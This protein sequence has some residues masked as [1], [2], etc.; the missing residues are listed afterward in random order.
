MTGIGRVGAGT[1]L[2]DVGEESVETDELS[3]EVDIGLIKR[4]RLRIGEFCLRALQIPLPPLYAI[5]DRDS[6]ADSVAGME[7]RQF[8]Q[9]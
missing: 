3:E 4:R 1:R 5:G 9:T 2:E 8:G 6:P 7:S